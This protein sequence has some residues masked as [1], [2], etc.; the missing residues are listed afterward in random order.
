MFSILIN[1]GFHQVFGLDVEGLR[2]GLLWAW[3]NGFKLR[4]FLFFQNW[5]HMEVN[6]PRGQSLYLTSVYDPPKLI[7]RCKLW[8]FMKTTNATMH[9]P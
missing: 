7:E 1:V 2:G 5:L 8:E 6:K 9:H 4:L 3:K